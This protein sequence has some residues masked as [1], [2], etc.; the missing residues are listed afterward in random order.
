LHLDFATAPLKTVHASFDAFWFCPSL[1][2][3]LTPQSTH[4]V[5]KNAK[6]ENSGKNGH[7][8]RAVRPPPGGERKFLDFFGFTSFPAL[9][10]SKKDIGTHQIDTTN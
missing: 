5:H 8:L 10:A 7:T 6:I 1:G 3:F 4:S 2:D 9:G